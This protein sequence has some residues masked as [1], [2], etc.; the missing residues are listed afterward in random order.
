MVKPMVKF[1]AQSARTSLPDGEQLRVLRSPLRLPA[2]QGKTSSRQCRRG[3][4][5]GFARHRCR[6]PGIRGVKG[7]SAKYVERARR[8]VDFWGKR[9]IV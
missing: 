1:T 5:G 2:H 7:V 9:R 8:F 6:C 3:C 4:L